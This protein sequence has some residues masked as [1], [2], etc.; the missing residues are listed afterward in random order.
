[1]LK[2]VFSEVVNNDSL[3]TFLETFLQARPRAFDAMRNGG[4]FELV[5]LVG[6]DANVVCFFL[7]N[8]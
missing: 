1:M 8:Y 4:D 6:K 5:R 3:S 7:S 2:L